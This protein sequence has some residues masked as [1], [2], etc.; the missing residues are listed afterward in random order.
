[1]TKKPIEIGSRVFCNALGALTEYEIVAFRLLPFDKEL[2]CEVEARPVKEKG[3]LGSP[4]KFFLESF[5]NGM[6][7]AEDMKI[8]DIKR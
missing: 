8:S 2:R 1:M 4:L 6:Y 7:E 5:V 3:E